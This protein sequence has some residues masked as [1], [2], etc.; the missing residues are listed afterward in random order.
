MTFLAP[1][2]L[3]GLLALLPLFAVYLLKVRPNRVVTNAWFLWEKVFEQKQNSSL[4]SRLRHLL[5]F[6][7]L[8]LAVILVCLALAQPRFGER[9][10]KDLLI[11]IDRSASMQSNDE[12]GVTRLDEAKESAHEIVR[13]LTGDQRAL[14]ATIDSSLSFRTHLSR[15]SRELHRAIDAITPSAL[16]LA[17]EAI[18]SLPTSEAQELIFFTDG[19]NQTVKERIASVVN[20]HRKTDNIGIIAADIQRLP[21]SELS[22]TCMVKLASSSER[23]QEIEIEITNLEDQTIGKLTKTQVAPGANAPLFFTI[24]EAGPGHWAIRI[25]NEDALAL[26]NVADLYLRPLPVLPVATATEDEYFYQRCIRAFASSGSPI[27][28]AESPDSADLTLCQGSIPENVSGN[29]LLFAPRGQ[30]P[31]YLNPGDE[32]GIDLAITARPEHPILRH[33]DLNQLPFSGAI[34]LSAPE[35]ATTL[36]HAEDKT[37]LIYLISE[38]ERSIVIVNLDP[39]QRNFYLSPWFPVLI[40]DTATYLGGIDLSPAATYPTGFPLTTSPTENSTLTAPSNQKIKTITPG[41][42]L[43]LNEPGIYQLKNSKQNITLAAALLA[44]PE[45]IQASVL[46]E[47][48]TREISSLTS[49]THWLILAAI[50]IILIEAILYH[51]RKVG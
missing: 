16:P 32:F 21:G 4:F 47:S 9:S 41:Q 23:S 50:L 25:L 2:F 8:A 34:K 20:L 26:D 39:A 35:R 40:Y 38:P 29:I 36:V 48:G 49:L 11:V 43:P 46:P 15:N 37:P 28:L 33:L 5:S 6:L 12:D 42:S 51:R 1:N 14:I 30:S 7:L 17:S 31:H 3:W 45:T 10:S 13:S 19:A 18:D 44:E 24:P 22:A 27:Q